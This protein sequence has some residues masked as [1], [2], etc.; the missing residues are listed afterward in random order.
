M[1][2]IHLSIFAALI[3]FLFFSCAAQAKLIPDRL[4]EDSIIM[5]ENGEEVFYADSK[6]SIAEIAVI[7]NLKAM[8][9]FESLKYFETFGR[10]VSAYIISGG[11]IIWQANFIL[12]DKSCRMMHGPSEGLYYKIPDDFMEKIQAKSKKGKYVYTAY[13]NLESARDALSKIKADESVIYCEPVNWEKFDGYFEISI[14]SDRKE[15]LDAEKFKRSIAEKY[16]QSGNVYE[17]SQGIAY[18]TSNHRFGYDFYI[19]CNR[20]FQQDFDMPNLHEKSKFH[21]YDVVSPKTKIYYK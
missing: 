2:K 1:K 15:N 21:P 11:K 20:D 6:E 17:I 10:D 19:N 14:E 16:G 4:P 3:S 13:D 5:F 18:E 7:L 8:G 9:F 12:K